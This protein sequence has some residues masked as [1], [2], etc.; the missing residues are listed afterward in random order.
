MTSSITREITSMTS[1][2]MK[3]EQP[4]TENGLT[5]S[6]SRVNDRNGQA[7]GETPGKTDE[8]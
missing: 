1:R 8:D 4:R 5:E 7:L 3:A 6:R 2:T